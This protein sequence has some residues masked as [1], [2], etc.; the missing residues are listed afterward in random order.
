[1]P[2][3]KEIRVRW[4]AGLHRANPE[5]SGDGTLWFPDSPLNRHHLTRVVEAGND[6]EGEASHW[7]E[8]RVVDPA[9]DGR[10]EQEK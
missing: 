10:S 4:R 3:T 7:L 5:Q 2:F 8:V 9:D 6:L 1:M